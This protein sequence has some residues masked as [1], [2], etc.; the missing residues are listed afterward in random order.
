MARSEQFPISQLVRLDEV[1][2]ERINE[3][4]FRERFKTE[5]DVI[6]ELVQRGL[7]GAA[8]TKPVKA[9]PD[10]PRTCSARPHSN[11]HPEMM[12]DPSCP[13]HQTLFAPQDSQPL[14]PPC[15]VAGSTS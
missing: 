15:L 12:E 4:R 10:E 11:F 5:A 6:R 3:F 7:E 13:S 8:E 2:A 1:L 9:Q 14:Q